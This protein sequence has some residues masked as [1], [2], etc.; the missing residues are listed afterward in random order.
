MIPSF[1][2]KTSPDPVSLEATKQRKGSVHSVP[3]FEEKVREW[4]ESPP[5]A[6][7]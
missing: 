3:G 1:R 4:L 5:D 6:V 7:E 2:V